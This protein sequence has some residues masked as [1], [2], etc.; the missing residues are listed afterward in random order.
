VATLSV[1]GG[2]L[3]LRRVTV[4]GK[5]KT[6]DAPVTISAGLELPLS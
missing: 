5:T 1:K 2:T 6:F 3:T 4:N